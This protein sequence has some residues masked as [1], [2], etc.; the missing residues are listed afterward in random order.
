MFSNTLSS[1]VVSQQLQLT[2]HC[3]A[4]GGA[5]GQQLQAAGSIDLSSPSAAAATVSHDKLD[6]GALMESVGQFR[7][8][9]VFSLHGLMETF[10]WV[11][12]GACMGK[13]ICVGRP[14]TAQEAHDEQGC[15]WELHST[16]ESM[17]QNVQ[18]GRYRGNTCLKW[19]GPCAGSIRLHPAASGC[20]HR[21][22]TQEM[23][24]RRAAVCACCCCFPV[25][26][27]HIK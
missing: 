23:G 22:S 15:R 17:L 20:C 2:L 19:V 5:A 27:R 9:G 13:S 18:T 7:K 11:C 16:H 25:L 3:H 1:W 8:A 14:H 26:H 6:V 10:M 12:F 4:L 21:C 24:L